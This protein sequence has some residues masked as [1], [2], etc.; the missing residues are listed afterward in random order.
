MKADLL[1]SLKVKKRSAFLRAGMLSVASLF[2]LSSVNK[3]S[4][5]VR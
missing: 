2:D 1:I 5:I 3:H 4:H